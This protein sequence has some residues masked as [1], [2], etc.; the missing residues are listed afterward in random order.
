MKKQKPSAESRR[1]ERQQ[2]PTCPG[3]RAPAPRGPRRG[4]GWLKFFFSFLK[5]F[6]KFSNFYLVFHFWKILGIFWFLF[7]L[8]WN[9]I[10]KK[11]KEEE[12]YSQTGPRRC[13]SRRTGRRLFPVRWRSRRRSPRPSCSWSEALFSQIY[14]FL[15]LCIFDIRVIFSIIFILI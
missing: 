3:W 4:T 6:R 8:Y 10:A 13:R 1:S 9:F 7:E 5:N 2:S 15:F 14:F 12:H 11:W